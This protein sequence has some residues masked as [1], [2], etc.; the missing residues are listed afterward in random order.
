MKLSLNERKLF[1]QQGVVMLC[2][3][4]LLSL[5]LGPLLGSPA[6]ASSTL[7]GW[8]GREDGVERAQWGKPG[9]TWPLWNHFF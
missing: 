3:W 2:I 4:V 5:L 7:R 6:V 1:D 9:A 8:H